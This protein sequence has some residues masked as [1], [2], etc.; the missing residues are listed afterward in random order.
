MTSDGLDASDNGSG[1]DYLPGDQAWYT[2]FRIGRV[3]PERY[4]GSMPEKC[5][6][7]HNK[8][9]AAKVPVVIYF[10][11]YI[12]NGPSDLMSTGF[13]Q[14]TEQQAEQF[15]KDYTADGGDATVISLPDIGITGNSHFMFE[16][17]NN[18]EIA[19]N[20]EHW[21]TQHDLG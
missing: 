4:D 14:S 11:D 9:L 2:H 3:A 19:D 10:S 8:M 5:S 12:K 16:E 13:W 21:L 7:Q 15:A 6:D 18:K 20:I 17:M 1:K